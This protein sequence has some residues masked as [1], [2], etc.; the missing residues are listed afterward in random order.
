[1]ANASP[2]IG[3]I[4]WMD[5]TVDDATGVRDFYA[6]VA[7]WTPT[8]IP[9]GGHDDYSMLR[10]DGEAVAGVCH[11]L[12]ENA[13]IPPQWIIYVVVADVDARLAS[14]EPMGGTIVAPVR[15]LGTMGRYAL[16]RDPSGAVFALWSAS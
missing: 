9:M 14:V 8:A 10:P 12:G 13:G 16:V 4:G 15:S 2:P 7:G 5:L 1:M 6:A 11:A 3:S